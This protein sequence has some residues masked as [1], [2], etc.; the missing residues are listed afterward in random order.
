MRIL[1]NFC[2]NTLEQAS[3]G[4]LIFGLLFATWIEAM[5]KFEAANAY[6]FFTGM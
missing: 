3:A 1:S 4:F 6:L 2:D 5:T